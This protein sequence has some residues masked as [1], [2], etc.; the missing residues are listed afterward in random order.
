VTYT[1]ALNSR[2]GIEADF[3][4]TRLADDAFLAVTGT[5]CGSADLAR[6][7]RLARVRGADVRIA[8]V[9]GGTCCYALW[10]PL[11]RDILQPLTAAELGNAAFPFLTA[12]DITVGDIPVRA[13]RVT[14]VG[15]LGWELYAPSEYGA[16]LWAT[17][18]EAG[19]PA[20]LVAGGYRA[21]ES[22]RLE[23]GYRVWGT[24]VTPETTPYEAGLGFC[25]KLDKPFLGRDALV[26]AKAAGLT[27][28]LRAI[29]LDD[30]DRVVLG[31]EPVRV[32]D[33]IVGRV[34]SGGYGYSVGA[35][36][37]YAYVP[38]DAKPGTAVAVDLFGEWIDGEVV[39]EPL[40]DPEGARV[41]GV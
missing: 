28:R 30:P 35:S 25:V 16:T 37:A 15:E 7:R 34:T 39:A 32:D 29:V 4:V 36:I 33:R 24:D 3:T 11:A 26:E 1:Q 23:K 21:I 6:L 22:L 8:D 13:Q 20:G 19:R 14:F 5:A 41:K 17:L 10:G 27:R 12:Q 31:N 9:T 40:I 2:G 18:F 38:V